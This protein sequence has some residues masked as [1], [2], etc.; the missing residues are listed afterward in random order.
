MEIADVTKIQALTWSDRQDTEI[1]EDITMERVLVT[2]PHKVDIMNIE[3]KREV[4]QW[5]SQ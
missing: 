4:Q 5:I 1:I 2:Y 3:L